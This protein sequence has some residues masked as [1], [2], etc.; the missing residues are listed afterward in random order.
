MSQCQGD[1]ALQKNSEIPAEK[2]TYIIK[3]WN[4]LELSTIKQG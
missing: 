4:C 2:N 1:S 3:N